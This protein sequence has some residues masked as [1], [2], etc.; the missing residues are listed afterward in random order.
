MNCCVK[1]LVSWLNMD[2]FHVNRYGNR[3]CL[4]CTGGLLMAFLGVD[5]TKAV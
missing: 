2:I 1:I 4:G 3:G 5:V